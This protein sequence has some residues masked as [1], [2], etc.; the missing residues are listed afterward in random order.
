MSIS[1]VKLEE[2]LIGKKVTRDIIS[3]RRLFFG[4]VVWV[5]K[6]PQNL[7]KIQN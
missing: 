7:M 2:A 6:L 3:R 4:K 5:G 1:L